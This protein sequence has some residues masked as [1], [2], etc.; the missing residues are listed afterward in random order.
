MELI[1]LLPGAFFAPVIHEW[2]RAL[3]STRLGDT[4]PK[5][6]GFMSWNPFKYFEPVGFL[7][8]MIFGFG[9]GRTVPTSPLQYKN[10]RR[11]ILI[12][13]TIPSVVN[14]VVGFITASIWVALLVPV[15]DWVTVQTMQGALWT[16]SFAIG[17]MRILFLFAQCNIGLAIF[18]IIPIHP[19]DASKIVQLYASPETIA[20]MNHY[21]KPLQILL[22]IGLV[23]TLISW[24]LVP[25]RDNIVSLPLVL[26]GM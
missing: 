23:S 3:C 21:E 14:L 16:G 5:N 9:W 18:N 17:F 4:T 25:L 22:V 20:R 6:K 2:I 10:R 24:L 11:G 12:T 15:S 13:H 1:Y 26:F 8:M 19:L 7:F